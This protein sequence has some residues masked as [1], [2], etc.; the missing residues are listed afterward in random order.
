MLR[1]KPT[2]DTASDDYP[3][4][5]MERMEAVATHV[6]SCP[7]CGSPVVD[8]QGVLGCTGCDWVGR[9]I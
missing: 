5:V 6:T 2:R 8:G 9:A 1:R 4:R 7:A 3:Y